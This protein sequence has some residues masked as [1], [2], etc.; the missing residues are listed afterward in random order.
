MTTG[1]QEI[2][3]TSN[4]KRANLEGEIY[5]YFKSTQAIS[6]QAV[7]TF[8]QVSFLSHQ[9]SRPVPIDAALETNVN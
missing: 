1:S 3:L 9:N 7:I 5:R 2:L 6:W 8:S 4:G